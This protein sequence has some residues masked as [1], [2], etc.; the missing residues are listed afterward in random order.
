MFPYHHSQPLLNDN[1]HR[2]QG[3]RQTSGTPSASNESISDHTSIWRPV[4]LDQGPP[5]ATESTRSLR[6]SAQTEHVRPVSGFQRHISHDSAH[7][8]LLGPSVT[9]RDEKLP[10]EQKQDA[11]WHPF[12]LRQV[13]LGGF[14]LVFLCC[15][16]AL[17]IMLV[18]SKRN[19]GL[20]ESGPN[21]AYV[22][23][24]GPTAVI[25]IFSIFW[26]RV[27]FQTLRYMPWM[28]IKRGQ[29]LGESGY[30]LDYTQMLS[31]AVL[32]QSLRRKHFFVF[33]VSTVSMILKAQI[34]LSPGLYHIQAAQ[35]LASV[36]VQTLDSFAVTEDLNNATGTAP[37]YHARALQNFDMTFPFGVAKSGAYQTF[38]L[39]NETSTTRGTADAP[40]TVIVDGVFAAMKCLELEDYSISNSTINQL[41]YHN[42]TIDL[43]FEN[44]DR[45]MSI[46]NIIQWT[47]SNDNKVESYWTLDNQLDP[48]YPCTSLPQQHPNFLYYAAY[49]IPSAR[50]VSLP[51]LNASAA[52]IC[53][54]IAYTSKVKIIDDGFSPEMAIL[55]DQKNTTIESDPWV[56]LQNGI[57]GILGY[58]GISSTNIV[59]GP[60]EKAFGFRGKDPNLRDTSLY[61]SNVLA[62]AVMNL[63]EQIGPML[64]HYQLRQ[65]EQDQAVGSVVGSI[66]VKAN[67]L[68]V[69]EIICLWMTGLFG[70][71][72]CIAFGAIFYSRRVSHVWHRDPATLLGTMLFFQ[73]NTE[74][75]TDVTKCLS[76][77]RTSKKKEWSHSEYSSVVLGV[78][79]RA[80]FT[81]FVVSL[82]V[83]LIVAL[84][85][86][87][88]SGGLATIDE[89]GYLY[90]LW[91]SLPTL[92]MLLVSLNVGFT[93]TVMRDLATYSKLY[94]RPCDSRELDM[95]L[96]DMLGFR[97]LHHSIR[98]K[99]CA[100]TI[101]QILAT[102]C[103]FL[104][105]LAA[106]L[107]TSQSIPGS[108]PTQLEQDSWFGYRQILKNKTQVE[109]P[110]GIRENIGSLL[111]ARRLSNFTY[112]R[113]T[114]ADL[115]FPNL[116]ISEANWDGNTS[117][118]LRIPAAKLLP[119]C[120]QISDDDYGMLIEN[121][122]YPYTLK[123]IIS[124][125]FS[126]LDGS[127]F[128]HNE[129]IG[130]RS[131]TT[132]EDGSSY[133]GKLLDSPEN[134]G[135]NS[136]Y[137]NPDLDD[138]TI[139]STPWR[140]QT[141]MWGKFSASN[142]DFEHFS[143]WRC[144]YSWAEVATDLSLIWAN[145]AILIDHQNP[146]VENSS[147]IKPW[148]PPIGFPELGG[149]DG[150]L[151]LSDVF[152]EIEVTNPQAIE[153]S[154]RFSVLVE[155]F[156][157]LQ[158]EDFGKPSQDDVILEALHSNLGFVS[159]QL[160]NIEN[161]LGIDEESE[162]A[163]VKHGDL[164]SVN[165]T[166][167][168]NGRLR[169][170]Q[171]AA[172]TYTLVGIL[173]V[174][175]LVN[176]WALTSMSLRHK[177]NREGSWLLNM[178]LKGLAPK[179]FSSIAMMESL[180]HGSNFLKDVP[181]DSCPTSSEELH[182]WLV[183]TLFRIG[184]FQ[185]GATEEE[186][187]TVGV[188]EDENFPF[189]ANKGDIELTQ[190]N[191]RE[192]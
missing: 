25:T 8:P 73:G 95:S 90:L 2:N 41:G 46:Q 16:I 38:R 75:S 74:L 19:N 104:T 141:Y 119:T 93:D 29:S 114:Y 82:I 45:R 131:S 37:Y 154:N 128:E 31:P 158:V 94:H 4:R 192:L 99:L 132:E 103:A 115:V 91:K 59:M 118:Q 72:T 186:Q 32:Y 116:S 30:C 68:Q 176:V 86:S 56:M 42:F 136:F 107:L 171:N 83:G 173:S 60:V 181:A 135:F 97:A 133:I 172:M 120:V 77:D 148:S 54:P 76:G 126:C 160:A 27:E 79:F 157:P 102:F 140:V 168:D 187:F 57:P 169:L 164:P 9:S 53:S 87:D 143:F 152:P 40:L 1:F 108:T 18:C 101:Y 98:L 165:A 121:D 174:V 162:A 71:T 155:P 105:T 144:N 170:V 69:K 85:A 48:E 185:D 22:W 47:N 6:S 182:Q 146:P 17:P 67:K 138:N 137:C 149:L 11:R 189:L 78:W 109:G 26:S 191:T 179:G 43:K 44:C 28:A 100:V 151:P 156:G 34:I 150:D 122:T 80:M 127:S 62:Q 14:F 188:L 13:V 129:T 111:L 184:W 63:T 178:D 183:G 163:P 3:L 175:V 112:P 52:V 50:N 106:A 92:A 177:L 10:E 180:I 84:E 130:I 123:A 124:R 24:F 117:A 139:L 88:K 7:P 113:N 110:S 58:S 65:T 66:V 15:T 96:L 21:F 61:H 20:F 33:F 167:V 49:Y 89:E 125:S 166:I 147:T 134:V 12:W 55:P 190:E 81:M 39:A 70:V 5:T 51:Q 153:F 142:M 145:K 161:R 159:A 64:S 35:S 23:R 36:D